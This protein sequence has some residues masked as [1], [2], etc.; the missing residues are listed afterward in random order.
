MA[1]LGPGDEVIIPSPYWVSYPDMALLAE[2]EPVFIST[3][4]DDDFKITPAQL[5]AS[6][7]D[8]TRLFILNS[9]S[10]PTGASYTESEL[11]ALGKVL[12]NHPQVAVVS[13]E[14]YETIHWGDE[15]VVSFAAACPALSS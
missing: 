2:A 7:T 9:P 4:I 3:G 11:Q 15:P 6:L 12:E 13:D 5:A 8:K 10:N 14:I 1:L